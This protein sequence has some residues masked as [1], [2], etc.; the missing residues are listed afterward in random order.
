M[1]KLNGTLGA[2]ANVS[3]EHLC[4]ATRAKTFKARC[5]C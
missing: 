2:V 4:F 1:G 3:F 5:L